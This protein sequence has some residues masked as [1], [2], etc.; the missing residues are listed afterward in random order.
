MKCQK[1]RKTI[2]DDSKFCNHCGAPLGGK[3]KLYRRPDGL[4]TKAITYKGK[5][6]QFYGKTEKEVYN[7]IAAYQEQADKGEMFVD[8]ANRWHEEH[9]KEIAPTTQQGYKAIFDELL[10]Y[11]KED[12]IRQ[13][14]HKDI[15]NYM[16]QLP[17]TYAYSTCHH[18]L[19]L[20][21]LIFRYAVT[22]DIIT[23][24]PCSESKVP[25]GHKTAKRRAPTEAEI[26]T[27][28][29]S[30]GVTYKSFPVGVLAVF[31]LFTGLRKGEAL[32]LTHKDIDRKG[33]R[34]SVSKSAYWIGADVSLKTPKTESGVREIVLP[35]YLLPLLPR[36]NAKDYVFRV[37]PGELLSQSFFF[38]AW[39]HWQ[40]ESGLD[41]TAHQLRHGYATLLHE[42]GVD[43]K[44]AQKLLGH[45]NTNITQN[46][47]T[48]VSAT[49]ILAVEKKINAFIQ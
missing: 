5:R 36:G 14:T 48:D 4:Y 41:L 19:A 25:K 32:A 40:H 37:N 2:P 34:I 10:A 23:D 6:V 24:N 47:Y 33:K 12:Y 20:L 11:F 42:A 13:I 26:I 29:K 3:K 21:K 9:W 7:K 30:V 44:D 1:C 49:Q 35:D 38:S 46:V 17:K 43:I 16:K 28:K 22:E 27:I 45:A 8:V 31:L 15:A 18:R 39:H